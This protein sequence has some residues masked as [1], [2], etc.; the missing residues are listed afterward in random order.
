MKTVHFSGKRKTTIAKAT[1]R[2]GKGRISVNNK[3]LET[4][5]PEI[6]KIKIMEPLTLAGDVVK[7]VDI[8]IDV[9]GGGIN[10]RAEAARLAIAK[11]LAAY[12]PQLREIFLNYDRHLLIAD[13]RQREAR[14]PNMH[15]NARGKVQKSYR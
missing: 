3:P 15:G 4:L 6:F 13:V 2:E 7:Q 14:K 10:G 1:L 11:S 12:S 5:T 9:K 8:N